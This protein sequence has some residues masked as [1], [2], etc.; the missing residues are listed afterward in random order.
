L[1][2]FPALVPAVVVI[3]AAVH[4]KYFPTFLFGGHLHPW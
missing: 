2:L 1:N 4:E 3:D